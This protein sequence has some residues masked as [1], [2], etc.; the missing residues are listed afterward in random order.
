MT[1]TF[2]LLVEGNIGA[3]KTEFLKQFKDMPDVDVL[4]EPVKK[5]KDLDG[6]NL[7]K[8]MYQEP[9]KYSSLFQYYVFLTQLEHHYH[10]NKKLKIME[11]SLFSAR[12][13]F[14]E[15]FKKNKSI[16]P[17]EYT[18]LVAWFDF[19]TRNSGIFPDID[20]II[21]LKTSPEVVHTRIKKRNRIEEQ[22]MSIAYLQTLHDLHEEWLINKHFPCP[23]PL[24]IIDADKSI[25]EM[26]IDVK[27]VKSFILNK[28]TDK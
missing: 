5:W 15:N 19:L 13:C 25:G 22:S 23:A 6:F 9:T 27:K 2:T 26:S 16:H 10:C 3:G 20:L 24:M 7:L 4:E 18:V 11:R 8:A 12:Y 14:V 1:K 28:L 21:Y 17:S